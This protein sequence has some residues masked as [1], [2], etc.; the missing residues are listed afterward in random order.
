[1]PAAFASMCQYTAQQAVIQVIL[2]DKGQ[3]SGDVGDFGALG[4]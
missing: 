3:P 4:I 2:K 1:M